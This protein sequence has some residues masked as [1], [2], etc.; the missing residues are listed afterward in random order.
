[1]CVHWCL[2]QEITVSLCKEL[3]YTMNHADPV[4]PAAAVIFS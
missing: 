3:P 4:N 1:M 2:I